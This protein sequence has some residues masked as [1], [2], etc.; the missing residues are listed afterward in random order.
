MQWSSF[1]ENIFSFVE[2]NKQS[3]VINAVAG[4]GKGGWVESVIPTP[5][6]N[7]RFGDLKVGDY[8]FDKNGKPTK[9]LGVYPRGYMDAYRVT[10]ADGRSTICS[11]D[12]LWGVYY[13]G[14]RGKSYGIKTLEEMLSVG[15]IKNDKRENRNGTCKFYVPASGIHEYFSEKELAIDPYVLGAFIGNVCLREKYLTISSN[16]EECVVKIGNI[17]GYN[18]KKKH[19]SNYSWKFLEKESGK[20]IKTSEVFG[21][22]LTDKYSFEKYIPEEYMTA[23]YE[24]RIRLINGLFD[25]G[26]C[27][28]INRGRLNV[29]YCST[30]KKLIDQLYEL[31]LSIG[32]V[33]SIRKDKRT[34]KYTSKECYSLQVLCENYKKR[35]LFSLTRKIK[36][37]ESIDREPRRNY[38]MIG[39]SK[40]EKLENQLEIQCI[41]VDNEEHLYLCE[42]SIVTHNTSTIVECAKRASKSGKSIL[43]LAFNKSIVSELEKKMIDYENVECKTLHSHGFRAIMSSKKTRLKLDD[44]KWYTYLSEN[45]SVLSNAVFEEKSEISGYISRCLKLFDLCRINLVKANDMKAIDDVAFHHGIIEDYDEEKVVSSLLEIA[46]ELNDNVI[47]FVDM[48]TLPCMNNAIKKCVKKYDLIFVDECQDLSKAQRQLLLNS[49]KRGG[50]FIAVG[51]P[52][53]CQ[54]E[55]TLVT[56]SSGE[57][58][59]IEDLQIGDYVVSY[60]TSKCVFQSYSPN[61]SENFKSK[62]CTRVNNIE[63]HYSKDL[64]E[65]ETD[66]GNIT[67]YTPEH[68]CYAKYN[69]SKSK[70]KYALYLMCNDKGMYRIGKCQLFKNG[71]D[72]PFGMQNR[73]VS[74]KCNKGWILKIFDSSKEARLAEITESFRFQIPQVMFRQSRLTEHQ[75]SNE[76]I[77][78]M[79]VDLLKDVNMEDNVIRL[80]GKYN[81]DIRFPIHTIN[82]GT[83][84]SRHGF[85]EIRA[86]NL[87]PEIM[88]LCVFDPLNV[89]ERKHGLGK[90]ID[91]VIKSKSTNIKSINNISG[92]FKVYSLDVEKNHN[93]IADDIL[94]HNCINGFA[95]A[96]CDS[97]YKLKELAKGNEL[98]LSVCYRCGKNIVSLAKEIVPEIESFENSC[99]GSVKTIKSLDEL[100]AGDFILSRKLAPTISLCLR[101]IANG[102]PAKVKGKDMLEG[103]KKLIEKSRAK[104]FEQLYIFLEKE[105]KKVVKK[106][107]NRG[108]KEPE[109]SIQAITFCDKIECIKSISEQCSTF[110]DMDSKLS[111]LF[112][113]YEDGRYITLST[114]HKAKGLEADRVFIILPDTLPLRWR[115]QQEWE[116]EQEMNLKY[117]AITRAKKE[118]YFVDLNEEDLFSSM[119]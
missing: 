71:K 47:D 12:H 100:K 85:N 39:I 112:T 58:K 16:D 102:K 17:L 13:E 14:H 51:D 96:D 118:L 29:T 75:F 27:A 72:C 43:F 114:I 23:S 52:K 69:E 31:L 103:L 8:V 28:T 62:Y 36:V 108:N 6:G 98:P 104:S 54:P 68:I 64:I 32:I 78:N 45:F 77:E 117:V 2:N 73:M 57:K 81:K 76:D 113:D 60:N 79:Y 7:R 59:K 15:Y 82:G 9:V 86:C 119:Q 1:Q 106:V 67:R 89:C 21:N 66:S 25:T 61:S 49:I 26:G 48:I 24:S 41:Y 19:E 99:D 3:A 44:R 110:G 63:S 97:F 37:C 30:S 20:W 50:R 105:Y 65:V 94:T 34:D 33:S 84:Q 46:Y 116:K 53:Q 87:F 38:N 101:L 95:G 11:L 55:G 93:Y 90:R 5:S 88:D 56:L 115:G 35:C 91:K 92:K 10:L 42:N 111:N 4:S 40:I 109:N 74:E 83:R 80:L 70:N 22:I 107:W 18:I